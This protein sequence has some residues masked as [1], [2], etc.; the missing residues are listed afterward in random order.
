[1]CQDAALPVQRLPEPNQADLEINRL[2]ELWFWSNGI[3]FQEEF[4]ERTC[5]RQEAAHALVMKYILFN[6]LG[7][8]YSSI[9]F[10]RSIWREEIMNNP[11]RKL[12]PV[13]FHTP[14]N[15]NSFIC[16]SFIWCV[17]HVPTRRLLPES[18]LFV[19]ICL[20]LQTQNSQ[21]CA[22]SQNHLD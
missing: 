9:L 13:W 12:G 7:I 10:K 3:Y 4:W 19:T 5:V 18:W 15:G 6:C 11:N 22:R 21:G 1:M 16:Y 14:E 2:M 20:F 17:P 8:R